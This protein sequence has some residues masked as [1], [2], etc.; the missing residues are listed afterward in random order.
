[1]KQMKLILS[2][3]L[4][5][6]LTAATALTLGS[7]DK[8]GGDDAVT[9]Q[10]REEAITI[11][12]TVTDDK[13]TDTVFTIETKAWYL[14]GALEQENLVQGEEGQFGLYVK[15]V[16]GIEADYDKNGAYWGF[17]KG[18]VYLPSSIDQTLI[19]DGDAY[20]IVYTKG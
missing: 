8:N 18:G 4:V 9:T 20:E 5:M 12:V 2:L 15:F 7:C 11:T 17:Y 16:N 14:R 3:L 6:A 1:M 13:G 10:P 19:E